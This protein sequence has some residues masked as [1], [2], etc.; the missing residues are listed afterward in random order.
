MSDDPHR[1]TNAAPTPEA[2]GGYSYATPAGAD[3]APA[4]GP[5]SPEK[6]VAAAFAGG[7]VA[8]ILIRLLG[9]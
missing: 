9:R 8:A 7:V 1:P 3:V 4:D 2:V 5:T 6:Q